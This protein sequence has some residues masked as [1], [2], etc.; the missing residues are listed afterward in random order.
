MTQRL[1]SALRLGFLASTG[2]ANG[3]TPFLGTETLLTCVC[4]LNHGSF[5]LS[6]HLS[7]CPSQGW[8]WLGRAWRP[9]R[10]SA[11]NKRKCGEKVGLG[12]KSRRTWCSC[13]KVL[14]NSTGSFRTK[15]A[16]AWSSALGEMPRMWGLGDELVGTESCS[17]IGGPAAGGCQGTGFPATGW[18]ALS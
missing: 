8:G 16:H 2:L 9:H 10:R 14:T 15:G 13:E 4:K 17:G 11:R 12:R 5:F 6:F 3:T 18:Q 1:H 7:K